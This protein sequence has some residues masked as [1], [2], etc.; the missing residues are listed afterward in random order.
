MRAQAKAS[1]TEE[2]ALVA[3]L[4][5]TRSEAARGGRFR[6]H[7]LRW[8]HEGE[9]ELI[10]RRVE[11]DVEV[12]PQT[13]DGAVLVI[14]RAGHDDLRGRRGDARVTMRVAPDKAAQIAAIRVFDK[15]RRIGLVLVALGLA[16]AIANVVW[17]QSD[18]GDRTI[19]VSFGGIVA[20][21]VLILLGSTLALTRIGVNQ[22][23]VGARKWM[24][25]AVAAGC[26]GLIGYGIVE[27][28]EEL[29]RAGYDTHYHPQPTV[30][31]HPLNMPTLKLPHSHERFTPRQ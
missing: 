15:R 19:E 22:P 13:T 5:V 18:I 24:L 12:P 3:E 26:V 27:M 4:T 25:V 20:G 30:D 21:A 23:I 8:T 6:T 16:V 28:T 11:L 9:D 7:V 17:I 31:E 2:Q 29:D 1:V 14:A 10:R